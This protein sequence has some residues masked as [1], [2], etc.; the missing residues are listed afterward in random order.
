MAAETNLMPDARAYLQFEGFPN[1]QDLH[2]SQLVSS[3]EV[4]VVEPRIDENS[5]F[6]TDY[7]FT[8]IKNETTST[9]PSPTFNFAESAPHFDI[10]QLLKY[11]VTTTNELKRSLLFAEITEP[12]GNIIVFL[13]LFFLSVTALD[14]L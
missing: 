7:D 3:Q 5:T 8:N 9:I 4:P 11:D 13:R 6:M 12:V 1:T 10:S 14:I 2:I